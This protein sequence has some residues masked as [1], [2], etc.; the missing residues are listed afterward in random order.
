MLRWIKRLL[1]IYETRYE[2]WIPLKDIKISDEFSRTRIGERKW[3]R[4]KE[5]YYRTGE[6]Q[7]PILLA[8]DF[9]LVDGYSTYCICKEMGI[10]KVPICF[11]D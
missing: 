2:Y 3:Q 5:Y 6:F 1:G 4:K 8:R 11:I 7:S 9:I 10:E